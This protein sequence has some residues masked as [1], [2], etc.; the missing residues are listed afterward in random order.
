MPKRYRIELLAEI[1]VDSNQLMDGDDV[2]NLLEPKIVIGQYKREDG[3]F[4]VKYFDL[5]HDI[6]VVDG[7]DSD[8]I[9]EV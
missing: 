9:I 7:N 1:I 5:E 6:S 4:D 8:G 2:M 3:V